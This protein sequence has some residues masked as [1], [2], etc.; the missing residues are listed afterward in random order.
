L[1][2]IAAGIFIKIRPYMVNIIGLN[3][4]FVVGTLDPGKVCFCL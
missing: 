3:F 2:Y 4:E 1:V